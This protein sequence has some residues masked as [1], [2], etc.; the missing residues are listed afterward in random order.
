MEAKVNEA[1]QFLQKNSA[2]GVSLY[3]HLSEVLLKI[4]IE[5][6]SNAAESFEHIS[7]M[8][9][10]STIQPSKAGSITDDDELIQE[11]RKISKQVRKKQLDWA[12]S[13]LKLFKVPDEIPDAIPAFPDMMDEANM[14]EWAGISFG[15]EQTYRLYLSVKTLAESLNPDYESLRFWGK[16]NTRNGDYYIV[17]GRT[18]EDPE[19]DPM[20]QEGRDGSNRYTYWVAKSATSGWTM[21]PNLTMEQIVI[22]RQ[23][24]KL[25][26]G[27]LDAPV[28]SYP[29]FPGQEKHLLRAQIARI[30]HSTCVSPT[31]FF[32][33]DEDSEEP[34]IKLADA[35][36]IAESFPRPLEELRITGGWCHHEME[37]NVRGRCRPMPEVLDDDGE[38][39][40]DEN[41]PEEIE[42]L[43]TLDNDDE[44]AWTFRT[45]PGGAGESARSMVV[46]RSMVWPGAVAIAFGKRFTNIYVGYGL[47]FSPTSYTP[48][49]PL[50]LQK[51]WEPEEDDEPLL[52]SEDVLVDPNP[53]EEEDEDM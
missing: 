50:P 11:S 2:D 26:T 1:R 6:P 36:T 42:P 28:W 30:T 34:L 38:P 29:P 10:S 46:A 5:R 19:F 44:G 23:L 15:R 39:V 48:P 13:S 53:P 52:E 49:M 21:L 17:E 7:A 14:W 40:E 41:A 9:K 20:L 22:S 18:F 16:I 37:L 45:A 47:K 3:E 43:R 12:S 51:E 24:R 4:L 31:G 33:M 35:E 27:D 8:V 32:E 25:L